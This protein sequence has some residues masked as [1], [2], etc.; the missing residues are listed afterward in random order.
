MGDRTAKLILHFFEKK[1]QKLSA[2]E[3]NTVEVILRRKLLGQ[4]LP[5]AV[6]SIPQ[7]KVSK[8]AVD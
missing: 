7:M 5:I 2:V 3:K 1:I 4:L 6:Q 8:E